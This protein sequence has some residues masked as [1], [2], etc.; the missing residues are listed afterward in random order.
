M[1]MVAHLLP[2]C[3]SVMNIHIPRVQAGGTTITLP[4]TTDIYYAREAGSDIDDD[5]R[6]ERRKSS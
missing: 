1:P 2:L 6:P 3:D 4:R 5:G